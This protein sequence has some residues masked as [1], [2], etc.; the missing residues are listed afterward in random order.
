MGELHYLPLLPATSNSNVTAVDFEGAAQEMLKVEARRAAFVGLCNWPPESDA[1]YTGIIGSDVSA[2]GFTDSLGSG[3]G[4]KGGTDDTSGNDYSPDPFV[5]AVRGPGDTYTYPTTYVVSVETPYYDWP[6]CFLVQILNWTNAGRISFSDVKK[7]PNLVT[8][9]VIPSIASL[10]GRPYKI[11]WAPNAIARYQRVTPYADANTFAQGTI[12]S[13]AAVTNRAGTSIVTVAPAGPAPGIIRADN[14]NI[15]V[16]NCIGNQFRVF[17]TDGYVRAATVA[18]NTT[19][20]T[21]YLSGSPTWTANVGS[22]V[23]CGAATARATAGRLGFNFCETYT[24]LKEGWYG[25][26]TLTGSDPLSAFNKPAQ[27]VGIER[28][29]EDGSCLLNQEGVYQLDKWTNRRSEFNEDNSDCGQ[30]IGQSLNPGVFQ[31]F[32]NGRRLA[33]FTLV[34]QYIPTEVASPGTSGA[35]AVPNLNLPELFLRA[36][37]N[38]TSWGRTNRTYS[39]FNVQTCTCT[40]IS[41]TSGSSS[42]VY[43]SGYTPP[44]YAPTNGHT[45]HLSF[46]TDDG[47]YIY[48]AG[49]CSGTQVTLIPVGPVDGISAI[50]PVVTAG[51]NSTD[52]DGRTVIVTPGFTEPEPLRIRNPHKDQYGRFKPDTRGDGDGGL[53]V[54]DPP[55]PYNYTNG[56]DLSGMGNW[57]EWG[58]STHYI[59]YHRDG[60]DLYRV[61]GF[62]DEDSDNVFLPQVGDKAVYAGDNAFDTSLRYKN[63]YFKD[64]TSDPSVAYYR[65]FFIGE[66]PDTDRAAFN[67]SRS[68]TITAGGTGWFKTDKSWHSDPFYGG[69]SGAP[70]LW[71]ITSATATNVTLAVTGS[72]CAYFQGYRFGSG[73]NA[74]YQHFPIEGD[75]SGTNTAWSDTDERIVSTSSVTGSGTSLT[76]TL[77]WSTPMRSAPTGSIRITEPYTLSMWHEHEVTLTSG[78]NVVKGIIWENGDRTAFLEDNYGATNVLGKGWRFSIGNWE[79]GTGSTINY[80]GTASISGTNV[81]STN[82]L[83]SNVT[84]GADPRAGTPG[85]AIFIPPNSGTNVLNFVSWP[86]GNL[87]DYAMRYSLWAVPWAAHTIVQINELIACFRVLNAKVGPGITW[88]D[89][90]SGTATASLNHRT[91]GMGR[92]VA[93]TE[94]DNSGTNSI[95]TIS[96]MEGQVSSAY[97]ADSWSGIDPGLFDTNG[98]SDSADG[99][100]PQSSVSQEYT[101]DPDGHTV[102]KSDVSMDATFAWAVVP[103]I[104]NCRSIVSTR[105]V[106]ALPW[107]DVDNSDPVT[108]YG[109]SN[110]LSDNCGA[111]PIKLFSAPGGMVLRK[112]TQIGS[113][114]ST[115][116][117]YIEVGLTPTWAPNTEGD[118]HDLLL[119][120]DFNPIGCGSTS[121]TSLYIFVEGGYIIHDAKT[122]DVAD[123]DAT[124]DLESP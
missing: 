115:N 79:P 17:D 41:G 72:N 110:S 90:S 112:Y 61:Q 40:G 88:T 39:G 78:T 62:A 24:G 44:R 111:G 58:R 121:T 57:P 13:F 59:N 66:L 71:P 28:H 87:E 11:F 12:A 49:I 93:G 104:H 102:S 51:T 20:Q 43:V 80:N 118:P 108:S 85:T 64:I 103:G 92:R 22:G 123:F 2:T 9:C 47:N 34:S 73:T 94:F 89:K 82:R 84:G 25:V 10:A 5:G 81:G 113:T 101:V 55:L 3:A 95:Y 106:F 86:K 91:Y 60:T 56:S 65:R 7:I 23:W 48:S 124:A 107:L 1:L 46:H 31:S 116:D 27:T 29:Q 63:T 109:D 50:T 37:T 98:S 19:R 76:V 33:I 45:V 54:I 15:S 99:T 36:Q 117:A 75:F 53:V 67:A 26:G 100:P 69:T 114:S 32:I 74:V 52:V 70:N 8:C 14:L 4:F 35:S 96:W 38:I 6:I 77:N 97:A 16:T 30:P 119:D 83:W 18:T 122:I 42:T 68:G 120:S 21:I 105:N